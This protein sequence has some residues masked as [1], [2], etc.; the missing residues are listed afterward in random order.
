MRFCF[1]YTCR[2]LIEISRTMIA[3]TSSS[4]GGHWEGIHF[5]QA[6]INAIGGSEGF[7]AFTPATYGVFEDTGWYTAT[8]AVSTMADYGFGAG[9]GMAETR[10]CGEGWQAAGVAPGYSLPKFTR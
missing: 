3:G 8:L 7:G 10:E 1:V 5:A 9:C 6:A 2:R 4:R